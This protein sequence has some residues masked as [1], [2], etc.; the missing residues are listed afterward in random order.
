MIRAKSA[1][2][3]SKADP[4]GMTIKKVLLS[5]YSF[6]RDK[7][8]I[9]WYG[10]TP[11]VEVEKPSVYSD[12]LEEMVDAE[13]YVFATRHASESG[14][15]ALLTHPPGNWTD[16]VKLGGRPRRICVAPAYALKR[17]ALT[18]KRWQEELGLSSWRVGVEVT[19]HGPYLERTPVLFVELG[20]TEREWRDEHAAIAVAHAAVEVAT[21]G[22]R[23]EDGWIPAV[24]FGGPHYA[25][26]FLKHVFGGRYAIGH[27]IPVYVFDEVG[28]REIRMAF[29]RTFPRP[30]VALLDWKGLKR[31]HKEK[32]LPVLEDMGVEAVRA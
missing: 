18:L 3:V 20:S 2:I 21:S 14:F 32:L 17:A 11:L 27:I 30:R 8:G 5:L 31:P 13:L 6:K 25:P 9:Y 26:R 4:A 22:L 15:P 1:I 23:G 10:N 29:E 7:D 24:G 16:E 19:H 12:G 28:E